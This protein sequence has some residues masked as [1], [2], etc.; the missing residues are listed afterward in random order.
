LQQAG[1]IVAKIFFDTEFIENG[2]TIDLISIGMVNYETKEEL[3]LET[4]CDLTKANSWV[5]ENVILHLK[6]KKTSHTIIK[7]KIID[8]VGKSPEFWAYYASY[9]W[10]A[11]CQLY[12]SMI[13]L[14]P[15]WPMYCRDLKQLADSKTEHTKPP[16]LTQEHHALQDAIWNMK[17]YDHLDLIQDKL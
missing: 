15:T 6:G 3:Y 2:F 4:Y 13:D 8:F 16:S 9:D 12:G 1:I 7:Q 14:P 5:K 17:Y 11:L 10:V